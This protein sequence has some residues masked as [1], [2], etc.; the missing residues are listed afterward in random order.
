MN[1]WR[2]DGR[3]NPSLLSTASITL[4]SPSQQRHL[5]AS[6]TNLRAITSCLGILLGQAEEKGNDT[7]GILQSKAADEQAHSRV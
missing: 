6:V 7:E 1:G 4:T 2:Q 3:G 5:R